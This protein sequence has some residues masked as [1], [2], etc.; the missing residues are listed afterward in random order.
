MLRSFYKCKKDR[1]K[2]ISQIMHLKTKFLKKKK[3]HKRDS[4]NEELQAIY[5]WTSMWHSF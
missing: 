3:N 2:Y 5:Y 4:M 1:L